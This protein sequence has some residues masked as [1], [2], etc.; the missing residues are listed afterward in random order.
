M[1]M[2][3]DLRRKVILLSQIPE[4]HRVNIVFDERSSNVKICH[5]IKVVPERNCFLVRDDNHPRHVSLDHVVTVWP[6]DD[7]V[8]FISLNST[9]FLQS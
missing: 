5:F 9:R 6:H 3:P 1:F 4:N 8:T 7:H 2:L